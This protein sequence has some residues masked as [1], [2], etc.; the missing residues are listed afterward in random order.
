MNLKK[1]F[2]RKPTREQLEEQWEA[3]K[4][5]FFE[6]FVGP[7]KDLVYHCD[8]PYGVG[9]FLD[10]YPHTVNGMTG[11]GI[12]TR[13][14]AL[15]EGGNASDVYDAYEFFMLTRQ[16]FDAEHMRDADHPFGRIF[17]DIN[18][19]LNLLARFGESTK[20]NP[21]ETA[22]IP[23]QAPSV[24]GRCLIFDGLPDPD[25]DEPVVIC[26]RKFGLLIP[27]Q[28]HPEEM[29]FARSN[30]GQ[31]LLNKLK[32]GGVWPYSDIDRPSVV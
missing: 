2:S 11:T 6:V 21:G 31:M 12:T 19:I 1:L 26:G 13:E 7:L 18:G 10:L 23:D 17:R 16:E 5:A 14:L 24:G 28:I 22:R 20:F 27:I 15:L 32:D 30:G 4:E 8:F 9:G 3:Q 25:D 29:A